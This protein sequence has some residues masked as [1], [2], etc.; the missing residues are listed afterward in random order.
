MCTRA[1]KQKVNWR[2]Q[3]AERK[4]GQHN[5]YKCIFTY[6]ISRRFHTTL[7][8]QRHR[9]SGRAR[10]GEGKGSIS[11]LYD[12]FRRQ[13]SPSTRSTA[14]FDYYISLIFFLF[15]VLSQLPQQPFESPS[16]ASTFGS[17]VSPYFTLLVCF[18]YFT[19]LVC[20]TCFSS[21]ACCFSPFTCFRCYLLSSSTSV[22]FSLLCFIHYRS[23]HT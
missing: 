23:M 18:T 1:R 22:P 20:F 8:K 16:V 13:N 6:L 2:G 19:L 11:L 9:T 17:G 4:I 15:C 5:P 10:G 12:F 14:C 3:L 21:F 7:C